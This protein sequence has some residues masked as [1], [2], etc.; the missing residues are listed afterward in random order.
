VLD[1]SLVPAARRSSRL[2]GLSA[3]AAFFRASEG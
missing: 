2:D 1:F 3:L